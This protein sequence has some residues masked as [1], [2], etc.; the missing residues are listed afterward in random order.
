MGGALYR[1][2]WHKEV[3]AF[4]EETTLR[5]LHE[6]SCK[7]AGVNQVDITREYDDSDPSL[8]L[9]SANR[10]HSVGNLAH[11]HFAADVFS[12]PLKTANNPHGIYS[13]HELYAIMAGIFI[14]IFFDMDPAKS[15]P[16]RLAARAFSQQ[17]GK[18]IEANAKTVNMTGW[19]SNIA[20]TFMENKH[21]ALTDYG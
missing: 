19:V 13:E 15:F 18:L 16:L 10:L 1:E 8:D 6:K 21:T 14:G 3:T 12:L 7:I 4:Y 20:D 11:I 2:N 5:L 9:L 17:L